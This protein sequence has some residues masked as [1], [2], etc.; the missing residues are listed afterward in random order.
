MNKGATPEFTEMRSHIHINASEW[1]RQC[2]GPSYQLSRETKLTHY[3]F[4]LLSLSLSHPAISVTFPSTKQQPKLHSKFGPTFNYDIIIHFL[5]NSNKGNQL[6]KMILPLFFL[7]SNPQN[8]NNLNINQSHHLT[9]YTSVP[10][11]QQ[12]LHAHALP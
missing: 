12:L 10:L 8:N 6:S 1:E 3:P 7:F 9:V 4:S 2:H 11:P 5:I